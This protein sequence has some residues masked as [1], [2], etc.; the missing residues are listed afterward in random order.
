MSKRPYEWR[1]RQ[2]SHTPGFEY[3]WREVSHWF[4]F[5]RNHA[6][7]YFVNYLSRVFEV[8]TRDPGSDWKP[9][10]VEGERKA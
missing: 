4:R 1:W 5:S 6:A 3:Q 10:Q 2:R 7:R 9:Y 8:E